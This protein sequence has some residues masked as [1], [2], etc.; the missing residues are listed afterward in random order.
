MRTIY[1][2]LGHYHLFNMRFYYLAVKPTIQSRRLMAWSQLNIT[3]WTTADPMT[4]DP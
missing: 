3:C 2:E 1:M 4:H